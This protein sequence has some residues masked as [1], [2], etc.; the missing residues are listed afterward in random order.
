MDIMPTYWD[1]S[2]KI[3]QADIGHIFAVLNTYLM[4]KWIKQ[5]F[6]TFIPVL[7]IALKEEH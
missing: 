3:M 7:L 1:I 5:T 2:G 6:K 4:M